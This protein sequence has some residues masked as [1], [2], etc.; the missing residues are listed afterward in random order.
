MT[1]TEKYNHFEM[2]LNEAIQSANAI[3][4][5]SLEDYYCGFAWVKIEKGNHPFVNFLKAK[6]IGSKAWDKGFDIWS[7]ELSTNNRVNCS[8]S[9][10]LKENVSRAFAEVLR[11]YDIPAYMGS[12]AD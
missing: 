12:R 1:K 11:K 5:T 4:E 3:A 2:I 6:S 8:Q 9:M 10:T 7:S